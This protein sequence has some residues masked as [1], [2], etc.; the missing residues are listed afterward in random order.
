MHLTNLTKV[1]KSL[2]HTYTLLHKPAFI[3]KYFSNKSTITP[4]GWHFL[5]IWLNG[6]FFTLRC[7]KSSLV[8]KNGYRENGETRNRESANSFCY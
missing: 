7:S 5:I 2:N 1:L 4:F 3:P 6:S 8:E